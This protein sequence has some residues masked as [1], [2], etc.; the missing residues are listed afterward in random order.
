[1]SKKLK[2][3][4]TTAAHTDTHATSESDA[5]TLLTQDDTDGDVNRVVVESLA[6]GG[7]ADVS[8]FGNNYPNGDVIKYGTPSTSPSVS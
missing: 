3:Y 5:F 6:A 1:M 4:K 2:F 7:S 8:E